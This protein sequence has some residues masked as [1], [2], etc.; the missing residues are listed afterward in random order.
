MPSPL[1]LSLISFNDLEQFV[2]GN[3]IKNINIIFL[4]I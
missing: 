2:N 1:A 4:N 3:D